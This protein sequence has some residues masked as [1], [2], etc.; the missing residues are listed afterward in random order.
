M[1]YPMAAITDI[2]SQLA[3][4]YQR[5]EDQDFPVSKLRF[6]M[7]ILWEAVTTKPLTEEQKTTL[8]QL[9]DVLNLL[10]EHKHESQKEL[11]QAMMPSISPLLEKMPTLGYTGTVTFTHLTPLYQHYLPT[12]ERM[13]REAHDFSMDETLLYYE[14]TIFD[15]LFLV[16][17]F[18][19]EEQLNLIELV[20]TIKAIILVNAMVY[21][22]HQ[23]MQGRSI[24]FFTFLERGGKPHD[25]LPTFLNTVIEK[26]KQN[27]KD[28][29]SNT[30]CLEVLDFIAQKLIDTTKNITQSPIATPANEIP[31]VTPPIQ[32]TELPLPPIPET[33]IPA[34]EPVVPAP[35]AP[36]T[37]VSA[38]VPTQVFVAPSAPIPQV[39]T[40]EQ[41]ITP[42]AA[43][44]SESVNTPAP[45]LLSEAPTA[46]PAPVPPAQ[47]GPILSPESNP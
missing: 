14:A 7:N 3:P 38:Q 36:A 13:V 43:P 23:H 21:D 39:V 45:T 31:T 27:A 47:T 4:T 26:I 15:H 16:H 42:T 19:N 41:P 6:F 25:E 11:I 12:M 5:P 18:E 32:P 8:K 34:S 40:P 2:Y 9:I 22:Y 28:V 35:I 10:D 17:L 29:I 24:S 44:M 46:T 1:E 30:T 37:P 33:S 20:S